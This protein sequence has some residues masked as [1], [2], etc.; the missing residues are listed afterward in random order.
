MKQERF[1]EK[2]RKTSCDTRFPAENGHAKSRKLSSH[3]EEIMVGKLATYYAVR[4]VQASVITPGR[5]VVTTLLVASNYLRVL[6]RVYGS[7]FYVWSRISR[8]FHTSATA[9]PTENM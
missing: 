7:C 6:S 4:C 5:V 2:R 9:E 1:K 3:M 8:Y